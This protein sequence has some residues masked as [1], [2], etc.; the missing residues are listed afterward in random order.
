MKWACAVWLLLLGMTADA[1]ASLPLQPTRQITFDTSE[2]TWIS[3]DVSRDGKTLVFDLLG[4]L[5]Q[6]PISGGQAV[7]VTSGLAFD[8][9]PRYSPDGR[10]LLFVSDRDGSDNVWVADADGNNARQV[11]RETNNIF[12]SPV[13]TPD[14]GSIVVSKAS[15]AAGVRDW[16]TRGEVALHLYSLAGG[17]GLKVSGAP[18]LTIAGQSNSAAGRYFGATFGPTGELFAALNRGGMRDG[19]WQIVSFDRETAQA[20]FRTG[21]PGSAMRPM[22]SPDG[23]Y[24][25]YATRVDDRTEL[26]LQDLASGETQ[27][28]VSSAT[29][30][31]QREGAYD[32]SRDLMPG[33]AFTP[34]GTSIVTSYGGKL[35]RVDVSSGRATAIP[36]TAHIEQELGPLVKFTQR[37]PSDAPTARKISDA[38]LS[39]D[40]KRL[41]VSAMERLWMVD[42]SAGSSSRGA[43]QRLTQSEQVESFPAWSPDGQYV[44][45]TTWRDDEG[46]H[47]YRMRAD[48]RGS[49]E[50]LTATTAF[51]EKPAYTPDGS[52]LVAVRSSR[53]AQ[54]E[55]RRSPGDL[56]SLPANGGDITVIAPVTATTQGGPHF[57]AP[58]DRVLMYDAQD[59][60]VSMRLDGSERRAI[61]KVVGRGEIGPRL[62]TVPADDV[63][64][65][66]DGRHAVA[67]MRDRIYLVA[68]PVWAQTQTP[69]VNL[70]EPGAAILPTS[71]LDVTGGESPSWSVDGK[72]L[73]WSL[74]RSWFQRRVDTDSLQDQQIVRTDIEIRR[75][76]AR[77]PE[78]LVM[79]GARL[80]TMQGEQVIEN[81][82]L[83]IAD[84]KIAALGP[85]GTVEIPADA[86]VLDI[87][88]KTVLPGFIDIDAE[89]SPNQRWQYLAN[90]AYGVT[91]VRD[92]RP[93]SSDWM[94]DADSME[95]G[96]ALGPRIVSS[97]PRISAA[98]QLRSLDEARAFL[99]GYSEHYGARTIA[100]E[101]VGERRVRQW[102]AI[103]SREQGLSPTAAG[104]G[105]LKLKLT[106]A[107]DGYAGMSGAIRMFP[108]YRDVIEYLARSGTAYAL[109][110]A[111]TQADYFY[112]RYD[113]RNESKLL[114]LAPWSEIEAR[115]FRGRA[116][117]GAYGDDYSF[118]PKATVAAALLTA[119]GKVTVG[120][121]GLLPGLGFHWE[122]WATQSGGLSAHSALLA[123]TVAN[124][125]LLGLGAELG[126]LAPGKR[127]DLQ[128]LD[129]NPLLD[130]AQTQ[131]IRYV[132][133]DGRLYDAATLQERSP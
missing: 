13:W 33:A 23:R 58:S 110:V 98:A 79:R 8:S 118:Q 42:V 123:A 32:A 86:R 40:G 89:L 5:Y 119:G 68:I 90:L 37:S 105:D 104:G 29:P 16:A 132:V 82:D 54:L 96:N 81:G 60:L 111:S 46:G 74:G 114:R 72:S 48:G 76:T 113:L 61:V 1:A 3:V 93:A 51:Y 106:L 10:Q 2:G 73:Y 43:A 122:L 56:V 63:I 112:R 115:P 101:H 84:S 95:S 52:R 64:L 22:V 77:A 57:G 97:G 70:D 18:L 83:V 49:P 103:A 45:Y 21:A 117:A 41:V 12:I 38:R 109:N 120:S 55:S 28:L 131:S 6:L 7:R 15:G 59:G 87:S 124:A 116:V 127:A 62:G 78:T 34:D 31:A 36:F 9:Q 20:R 75:P 130:I 66:P 65:S 30:D 92:T 88:G 85:R 39:P 25:V 11:T 133:K 94:I 108:V 19:S 47:I 35:W 99:R 14:G 53:Q 102:L 91:T 67:S 17:A 125:E 71:R 26:R 107:A 126:S 100:Q 4:D 69:V 128:V 121:R 129:G 50:R 24:L 27:T 44:A 80:I